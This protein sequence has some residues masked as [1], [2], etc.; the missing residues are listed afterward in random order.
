MLFVKKPGGGLYFCV[1]YR[2][3]NAIT[4]YDRYPLPLIC[5]TLR[6]LAKSQWFTKIDMHA[7]F[8]RICIKEGDKWKT[9][10]WTR[11]GLFKWLVTPFG[12]TGAP[13][14]FQC[15][16]NST[17]SKFL[18]I[19]CSAYIDDMLIYLDGSYKDHIGKVRQVIACLREAGLCLDINKCKFAAKEV[20]Y[21]GFIISAGEGIKVDP[22]KVTAI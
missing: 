6:S 14:I 15:Y 13:T 5:E 18:D 21:L 22:E 16:I 17:L 9:A 3:L 4:K 12:L 20:K 2:A 11:F 7:A 10:F 1:D 8:H 19:F